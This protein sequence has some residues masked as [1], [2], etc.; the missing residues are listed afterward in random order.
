MDDAFCLASGLLAPGKSY[1][2]SYGQPAYERRRDEYSA[3][4]SLLGPTDLA[5]I[6]S[7]GIL[8]DEQ[9]RSRKMN[10]WMLECEFCQ[11]A[12]ARDQLSSHLGGLACDTCKATVRPS[13]AAFPVLEFCRRAKRPKRGVRR[14]KP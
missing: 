10:A 3:W 11:R 2:L 14:G 12:C 6:L 8:R 7:L 5:C 9:E 13:G 1:P 4:N